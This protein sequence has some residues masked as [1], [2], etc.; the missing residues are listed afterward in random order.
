MVIRW[1]KIKYY[2]MQ[3]EAYTA[4]YN[5]LCEVKDELI[6]YRAFGLPKGEKYDTVQER[7]NIVKRR[8]INYI[9][10]LKKL[11]ENGK[12]DKTNKDS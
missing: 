11:V 2:E 9:I 4:E 7:L 1:L 3:I 5:Y 10:R 6:L 12:V 8:R